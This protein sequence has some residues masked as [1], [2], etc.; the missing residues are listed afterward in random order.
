MMHR[1]IVAK[2][3]LTDDLLLHRVPAGDHVELDPALEGAAVN[4]L[5]IVST[6]A[7]S[8]TR[9]ALDVHCRRLPTRARQN[10]PGQA[11]QMPLGLSP[12]A[13]CFRQRFRSGN[14][15]HVT[16]PGFASR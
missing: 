4:E 3:G 16:S 14:V 1:R 8:L 7:G 10:L 6:R 9:P 11:F 12:G 2:L 15:D 13:D 5:P